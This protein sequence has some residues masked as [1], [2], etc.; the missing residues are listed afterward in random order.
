[1]R[2]LVYLGDVF[3]ALRRKLLSLRAFCMDLIDSSAFSFITYYSIDIGNVPVMFWRH[4]W[5]GLQLYIAR[6][7]FLVL[8]R[9]PKTSAIQLRFV[10]DTHEKEHL[11]AISY[12]IPIALMTVS[13]AKNLLFE[14]LQSPKSE[15]TNFTNTTRY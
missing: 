7:I 8:S 4:T 10:Y 2:V 15:G 13:L 6:Y 5:F 11:L 9:C 12:S 1:M 14:F 3:L